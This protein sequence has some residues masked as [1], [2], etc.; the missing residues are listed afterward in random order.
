ML[1]FPFPVYALAGRSESGC[2]NRRTDKDVSLVLAQTPPA[3]LNDARVYYDF[4]ARKRLLNE[5]VALTL[6][7]DAALIMLVSRVLCWLVF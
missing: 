6:L 1:V 5:P 7:R 3:G 2:S 4:W